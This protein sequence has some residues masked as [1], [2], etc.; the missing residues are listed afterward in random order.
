M[1]YSV[2]LL[3]KSEIE[4]ETILPFEE[5][6]PHVKRAA[7]LISEEHEIEGFRRG[8]APYDIV[9]NKFGEQAIYERAAEVAVR[10]S[11]LKALEELT[12]KGEF[13]VERPPIG[14]PEI[15]ITKLAPGNELRYK[16]KIAVLPEVT[17]PDWRAIAKRVRDKEIKDISVSEKEVEDTLQWLRESRAPSV[18]VARGAQ[19]D[20]SVEVDFEAR[21]GGVKIANGES[22]NHPLVLGKGKFMPGFEE[23]IMGMKAGERKEFS[24]VAPESWPEKS[25]A[26]KALDFNVTMKNVREKQTPELNDEFA[27]GLG[28]LSSVDALR[29]S[30][31]E[32]IG[33][34]KRE[35]EKQRVRSLMIEAVAKDAKMDIP[36]A[37]I[38]GEL[39]K[40]GEELKSGVESMG[41]KWEDYLLHL[42]KNAEELRKDWRGEAERRAR[43]ALCLREIAKDAKIEV[44][45][46]EIAAQA[47]EYLQKYKTIEEAEKAIDP[48]ALREYS[49]WALRNEKVFEL[50]ETV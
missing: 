36:E 16:V 38:F 3:P 29:Q 30:V 19:K 6:E 7:V 49:K 35:R 26:G 11:Y 20:D 13:S 14:K 8:K 41:M 5:F 31:R 46:K 18:A 21:H 48:E 50:L 22:K 33:A 1:N 4:I 47:N 17:L 24:L 23:A 15:V 27:K 42:K 43:A 44:E 28:N 2:K 45:E 10:A 37:L 34:E 40:M 12:A 9:E 32:G 25:L 39:D